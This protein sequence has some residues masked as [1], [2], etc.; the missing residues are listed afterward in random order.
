M[1]DA[2]EVYIDSGDLSQDQEEDLILVPRESW[3]RE[4]RKIF[5][6]SASDR[7]KALALSQAAA[8]MYPGSKLFEPRF[9]AE[10]EE[11]DGETIF[12]IPY[13]IHE[14]GDENGIETLAVGIFKDDGSWKYL[15]TLSHPS[16]TSFSLVDHWSGEDDEAPKE[17]ELQADDE[18]SFDEGG[19]TDDPED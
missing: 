18:G 5:A 9:S 14:D 2:L 11:M 12:G 17:L 10:F 1:S 7:E 8:S 19:E 6:S 13:S 4:L 16:P 3:S 15:S